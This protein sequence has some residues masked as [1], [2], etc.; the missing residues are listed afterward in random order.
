MTIQNQITVKEF[1]HR[2]D[3]LEDESEVKILEWYPPTVN[4]AAV[5]TRSESCWETI[6]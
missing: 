1:N 3:P 2:L 4:G 6:R 5:L